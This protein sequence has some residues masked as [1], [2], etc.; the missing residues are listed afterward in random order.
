MPVVVCRDLKKT[1]VTLAGQ[2]E[3]LKGINLEVNEGELV[4]IVGPSGSGKTTLLSIIAGILTQDEGECTVFDQ[5]I[6]EMPNGEKTAFRGKN[7]GFVF[8]TFNLVPMLTSKE[9]IAI[10]LILNGTKPQA[11]EEK[12]FHLLEKLEIQDKADTPPTE[13]SGGQQQRV[14]IARSLIHDPKLIICDEPTAHLDQETGQK[15]M[16]LLKET[17]LNEKRSI[18]VVT[19]DSRI[20]EFADKIVN[21]E[22]GIIT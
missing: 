2:V 21:I 10:P 16:H 4:I 18:I 15:V 17:A 3:A 14:A 19:H 7:I 6:N 22:D 12:A 20:F 1:Y 9:N 5:N 8:Q 11:A 13:L